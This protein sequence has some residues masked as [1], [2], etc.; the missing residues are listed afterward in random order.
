MTFSYFTI[1]ENQI[2]FIA[3]IYN[4]KQG[5]LHAWQAFGYDGRKYNKNLLNL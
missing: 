1:A 2:L 5:S 4:I 3:Y